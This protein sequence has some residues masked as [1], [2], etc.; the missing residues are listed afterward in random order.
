[1]QHIKEIL[2]VLWSKVTLWRFK[3][4]HN[5]RKCILRSFF[6]ICCPIFMLTFHLSVIERHLMHEN[7]FKHKHCTH[8]SQQVKMN[9]MLDEWKNFDDLCHAFKYILYKNNILFIDLHVDM[10][11]HCSYVFL[12]FIALKYSARQ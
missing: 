11:I 1:M 4:F 6:L 10:P 12:G 5:N 8:F 7:V 3:A 9:K 2:T